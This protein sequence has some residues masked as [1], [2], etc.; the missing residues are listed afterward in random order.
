M[1]ERWLVHTTLEVRRANNG[2]EIN[3]IQAGTELEVSIHPVPADNLAAMQKTGQVPSSTV[4]ATRPHEQRAIFSYDGGE[5][6]CS[7]NELKGHATR[8]PE[9]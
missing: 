3:F 1:A 2:T 8:I 9:T 6:T 7:Y 4:S 5:W